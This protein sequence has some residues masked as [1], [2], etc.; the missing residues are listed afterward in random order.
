MVSKTIL[1]AVLLL[2]SA[3]H[4]G[5]FLRATKAENRALFTLGEG[6][7]C[8][9]EQ[10]Y[11]IIADAEIMNAFDCDENALSAAL[12]EC[13]ATGEAL[14]PSLVAK[15]QGIEAI[16]GDIT[17]DGMSVPT[18]TNAPGGFS[19]KYSYKTSGSCKLC[20]KDNGDGFEIPG[21]NEGNEDAL[22]ALMAPLETE[23]EEE[24]QQQKEKVGA[25]HATHEQEYVAFKTKWKGPR[26]QLIM[27]WYNMTNTQKKDRMDLFK[28]VGKEEWT[29]IRQMRDELE[30]S[31]TNARDEWRKGR[32]AFVAEYLAEYQTMYGRQ[33]LQLKA[34]E[35]SMALLEA[36]HEAEKQEIELLFKADTGESVESGNGEIGQLL[37]QL[38]D[39]EFFRVLD[40]YE[41]LL[42]DKCSSEL[43]TLQCYATTVPEISVSFEGQK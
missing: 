22:M 3:R 23:Q 19:R 21:Q 1:E 42:E 15:A 32:D 35:E 43:A 36:R 33:Q 28:L 24:T 7:S 14:F 30:I 26:D 5:A 38:S 37:A 6:E 29:K 8:P 16:G 31:H 17:T 10:A 34:A 2:C 27:K 13:F 25:L 12:E 18:I 39:D 40:M 9:Y 4:A 20:F 41:L 11:D